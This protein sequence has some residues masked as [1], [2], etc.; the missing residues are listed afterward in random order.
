M[1]RLPHADPLA[2]RTRLAR[3]QHA[4]AATLVA[5]ATLMPSGLLPASMEA[6]VHDQVNQLLRVFNRLGRLKAS[7]REVREAERIR[8]AQVPC[9]GRAPSEWRTRDPFSGVLA[10]LSVRGRET[11]S[12]RETHLDGVTA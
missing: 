4:C 3:A 7:E 12:G 6:R 9:H 5:A 2:L 11:S 10:P 8:L 1:S